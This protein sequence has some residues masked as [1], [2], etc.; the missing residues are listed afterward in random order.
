[1]DLFQIQID[2]QMKVKVK[3]VGIRI[4]RRS[5]RYFMVLSI[6]ERVWWVYLQIFLFFR[7]C[8]YF[9]FLRFRS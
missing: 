5:V 9:S 7:I 8:Y 6:F 3:E 1:M 4:L 2:Y